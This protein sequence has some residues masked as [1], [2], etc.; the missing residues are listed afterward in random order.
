MMELWGA[1][2]CKECVIAKDMLGQTPLEWRYVDVA[3]TKY[4]GFIPLLITEDSQRIEG[5]GQI[6][7]YVRKKLRDM[8]LSEGMI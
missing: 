8:G 7:E 6:R 2:S 5:L 1:D 4:E 3:Q